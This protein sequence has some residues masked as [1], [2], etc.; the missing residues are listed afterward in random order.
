MV[1]W[2]AGACGAIAGLRFRLGSAFDLAEACRL[3]ARPENSER[4]LCGVFRRRGFRFSLGFWCGMV[5]FTNH[6]I[7]IYIYRRTHTHI[8]FGVCPCPTYLRAGA[9]VCQSCPPGYHVNSTRA[10]K[11]KMCPAGALGRFTFGGFSHMNDE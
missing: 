5:P 3:C 10:S 6:N 2:W 1:V 4:P 7:V 8:V 11:C 9:S